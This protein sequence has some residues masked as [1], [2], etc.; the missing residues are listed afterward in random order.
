L[1]HS[2]HAMW[3]T[4]ATMTGIALVVLAVFWRK[5]YLARTGR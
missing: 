2:A 1:I 4:L 5:R 3:G